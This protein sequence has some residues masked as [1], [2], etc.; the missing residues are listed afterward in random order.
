VRSPD[1][2]LFGEV[3]EIAARRRLG[4]ADQGGHVAHRQQAAL[5]HCLENELATVVDSHAE[6]YASLIVI[7]QA[8]IDTGP[9]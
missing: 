4:S 7:N 1:E 8:L 3:A 2:A 9:D 6:H 5:V